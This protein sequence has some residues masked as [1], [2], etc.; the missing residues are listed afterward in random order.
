MSRLAIH[1]MPLLA[2]VSLV[3]CST[4]PVGPDYHQ[5]S[6]ALASQSN[7]AA[8][9]ADVN[10]AQQDGGSTLFS[11]QTPPSQWWRLYHDAR[12]DGLIEQA[13]AYNTD[14]RQA[15]ANLQRVR[16]IEDEVAGA[17]KPAL[18]IA[19]G[20]FHGHPSGLDLSQPNFDPPNT[21]SYSVGASLSYQLD[22]FGQ[23]RRAIEAAQANTEAAQAAMDLVR[24]NVAAGTAR[25][26]AQIC[27]TGLRLQVAQKSVY[28]QQEAVD[29]SERLQRA[30]RAGTIDAA[31][32][33]GQLQQLQATLPPL[34]AERQGA[35][36]RLATLTGAFPQD[37]PR[38]VADCTIPPRV[39]GIVPVG[40]GSALLRRRPDIRQA[41]RSLAEATA[42]IGVITADLYPQVRLGLSAAS[43]GPASDFGG[44]DTFSWSVGPLISW[45]LPNTGA[46]HARIAQANASTRAALAKFDDTVLTA[47]RETETALVNYARELDRHAALQAARDENVSVAEQANRL[48]RSGKTGYL[49]ALDAE[50]ALA[51][52]ETALAISEA[53]LSDDQVALFL[54]LGGGW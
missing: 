5:P 43:A 42:R 54:A 29:M 32:A 4:T 18:D 19:G 38:D 17:Q 9:F 3:A 39:A 34:Q 41:E 44:K 45:T 12:L 8:P 36:F 2:T 11:A 1:I 13:L 25:A 26:Y 21:T 52:S 24:V 51:A 46:V 6:E 15:A 48:Y 31:R 30:G 28:L 20:E 10:A 37:F 16:A 47:L 14:L 7:A 40:D 35:L 22:L 33:R 50:R 49:D 53:Q 27:S 23:I